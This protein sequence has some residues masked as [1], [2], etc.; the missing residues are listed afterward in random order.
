MITELN[1]NLESAKETKRRG[2]KK[3]ESSVKSLGI[4]DHIKHIRTVQDPDYYKNLSDLDRKTFN[5]FMIL[6]G[7]SM[8]PAL[9]ENMAFLYKYFDKIPHAQ[10]YQL[11]INFVPIESPKKFYPW[12]K[13]KKKPVSEE[14]IDMLSR[15]YEISHAEALDYGIMLSKTDKGIKEL[16][17]LC[18]D[19]GLTEKEMKEALEGTENE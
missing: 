5:P 16:E 2:R 8:N 19:Y 1:D 9:V 15:Y 6:R 10:F 11:L 12:V 3:S 4:F 14:L 17:D 18:K 13:A 7:L